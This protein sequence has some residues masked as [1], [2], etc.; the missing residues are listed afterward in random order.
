[1]LQPSKEA[2]L[3]SGTSVLDHYGDFQTISDQ[4]A[5]RVPVSSGLHSRHV[6]QVLYLCENSLVATVRIFSL[7][8]REN[9]EMVAIIIINQV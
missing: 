5:C 7:Q 4:L 9:E 8:F 2:D 6:K 3:P 1:M